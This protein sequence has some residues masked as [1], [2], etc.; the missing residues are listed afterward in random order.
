MAAVIG[1][2]A[3]RSALEAGRSLHSCIT[4]FASSSLFLRQANETA[5]V[6]RYY[7]SNTANERSLAQPIEE[8]IGAVASASPASPAALARRLPAPQRAPCPHVL[9]CPPFRRRPGRPAA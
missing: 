8:E 3:G 4:S 1:R 2:L 7:R 9:G 5:P 6:H